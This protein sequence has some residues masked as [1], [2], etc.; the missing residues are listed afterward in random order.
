[1]RFWSSFHCQVCIEQVLARL[2][3]DSERYD[4]SNWK[5][6]DQSKLE[7]AGAHDS[8]AVTA[9]QPDTNTTLAAVDSPVEPVK[10]IA[11]AEVDHAN[12]VVAAAEAVDSE[13]TKDASK[14]SDLPAP[15]SPLATPA[16][17]AATRKSAALSVS[18]FSPKIGKAD[19]EDDSAFDETVT[20]DAP[21]L[22][23][24][25]NGVPELRQVMHF[26]DWPF[27][28]LHDRLFAALSVPRP[29]FPVL[30]RQEGRRRQ[31]RCTSSSSGTLE[32]SLFLI[33]SYSSSR[34]FCWGNRP[35]RSRCSPP[36]AWQLSRF[37]WYSMIALSIV[38][39]R[40]CGSVAGGVPTFTICTNHCVRTA[41]K[42]SAILSPSNSR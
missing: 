18:A 12:E 27:L 8:A 14:S 38:W 40:A 15:A 25:R 19:M 6:L 11:N 42:L 32:A 37:L 2:L 3:L 26:I 7:G 36:L 22:K 34:T 33:F 9:A 28:M 4:S 29:A 39:R 30:E 5:L 23:Y 31:C 21:V 10:D 13:G 20:P 41:Q 1:L 35:K 24:G 16:V 17:P